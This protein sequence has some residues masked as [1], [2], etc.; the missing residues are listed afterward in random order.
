MIPTR[1]KTE[2]GYR[3]IIDEICSCGH[4]KADHL[5]TGHGACRWIACDCECEQF[6]WANFIFLEE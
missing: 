1:I 3:T 6:T 2:D 5:G 4:S